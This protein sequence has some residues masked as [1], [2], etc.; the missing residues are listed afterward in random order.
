MSSKKQIKVR[1]RN[2]VQ[3]SIYIAFAVHAEH[4]NA[5]HA[6]RTFSCGRSV[7]LGF[8][9]RGAHA[10][11]TRRT[12]GANAAHARSERGAHAERARRELFHA[13]GV[14]FSASIESIFL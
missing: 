13:G 7:L 14:S 6:A 5:A 11:R 1:H 2:K 9:R 3:G 4:A 10:E 8:R 12:R